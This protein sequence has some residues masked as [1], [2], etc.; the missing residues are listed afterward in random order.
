ML[1]L[2]Y[3]GMHSGAAALDRL[4]DPAAAVSAHY[5]VEEDGTVYR[6]V[7]EARRAWH[8]GVASWRGV[9]DVNSRSIGIEIVNPGHDWGYRPFPPVQM[10]SVVALCHG[11]VRRHPIPPAHVVGHSDVAPAR[12]TD[13]GERFD[14][15]GLAAAGIG[16]WH[17]LTAADRLPPRAATARRL[18]RVIGYDVAPGGGIAPAERAVIRA[19]QRRFRPARVDGALDGETMARIVAMAVLATDPA[20]VAG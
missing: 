12:K 2:H 19:F 17:G 14:W 1:V 20:A 16:L 10:A 8:A 15:P 5:L 7:D 11:L 6:L 3:T 18:L 4:C 13:P 9:T